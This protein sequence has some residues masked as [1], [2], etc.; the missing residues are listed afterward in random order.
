VCV[1]PAPQSPS[2]K[3]ETTRSLSL[4]RNKLLR[5]TDAFGRESEVIWFH[6]SESKDTPV[7]GRGYAPA[8]IFGEAKLVSV[9][10]KENLDFTPAGIRVAFPHRRTQL[11]LET[12]KRSSETAIFLIIFH[13]KLQSSIFLQRFSF[14]YLQQQQSISG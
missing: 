11:N 5:N 6:E 10:Y 9:H 2:P 14:S 1:S 7:S 4:I 12:S 3:L 8:K 13:L